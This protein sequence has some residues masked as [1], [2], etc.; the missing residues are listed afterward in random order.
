MPRLYGIV[1]LLCA[2]VQLVTGIRQYRKDRK[3]EDE[4]VDSNVKRS[5]LLSSRNVALGFLV[6][7]LYVFFMKSLGFCISSTIMLICLSN[8]MLPSTVDR[9]KAQPIII[10]IAIVL[11]I[12]AYL[13]FKKVVF[14][15]LP[16]GP[17]LNDII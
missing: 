16:G 12:L 5:R 17:F 9:K 8:L 3:T 4:P 15:A 6:I 10:L 2:V 14:M 1:M 7:F 13:F 11:P